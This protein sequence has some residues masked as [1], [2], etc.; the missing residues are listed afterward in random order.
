MMMQNYT[1]AMQAFGRAV[2]LDSDYTLAQEN[3]GLC[4]ALQLSMTVYD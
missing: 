2:Q 4:E 3:R 1:E